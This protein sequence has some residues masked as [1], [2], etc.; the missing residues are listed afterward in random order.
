MAE[1]WIGWPEIVEVL[2]SV[3]LQMPS[4]AFYTWIDLIPLPDCYTDT[5]QRIMLQPIYRPLDNNQF[6][7]GTFSLK[8]C[9]AFGFILHDF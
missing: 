9:I 1:R 3:M 5:Y 7:K 4:F 6:W 8:R 2:F